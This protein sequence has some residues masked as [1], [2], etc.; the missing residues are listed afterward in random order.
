MKRSIPAFLAGGSALFLALTAAFADDANM[1]EIFKRRILPLFQAK[2]P[3]SCRECHLTGVDL[4][5]YLADDP[6]RAF[7][8]LRDQGLADVKEPAKSRLLALIAMAPKNSPVVTK[9]LREKERE[10]V[11]EWLTACAADA[12]LVASPPLKPAELAAPKVPPAVIRHERSDRVLASFVETIWADRGR[13]ASC[14]DPRQNAA[15]VKEV[16]GQISWIVPNDP[17]RTLVEMEEH[18]Y[19]D[20]KAPERSLILQKPTLGVPHGGGEKMVPGDRG[21]ARWL[22][23]VKDWAKV[24]STGYRT[25]AELPKESVARYWNTDLWVRVEAPES[26]V[27]WGDK[28]L[29]VEFYK[30]PVAGTAYEKSPIAT[31]VRRAAKDGWQHTLYLT[32]PAGSDRAKAFDKEAKLPTGKY[33][34]KVFMDKEKRLGK[35]PDGRL[36]D[37]DL[38]M[39]LEVS[40]SFD[41]GYNQMARLALPKKPK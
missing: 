15:K 35:T 16:G 11:L 29:V 39:T 36:P 9:E 17:A 12:E 34:V 21:H 37:S 33:Q 27:S 7:L 40:R 20:V 2:E 25:E 30:W 23:F 10:A 26:G 28:I 24:H 6:R 8:S 32:A 19:F 38:V 5:D 4:K 13:C 18:G 41:P 31:S 14:H 3:S 1:P 22:G